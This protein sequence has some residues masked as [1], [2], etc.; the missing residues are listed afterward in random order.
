M[1]LL[2][3]L[4]V[5]VTNKEDLKHIG[6]TEKLGLWFKSGNNHGIFENNETFGSGCCPQNKVAEEGDIGFTE[7]IRLWFDNWTNN[8]VVEEEEACH[9]CYEDYEEQN[10]SLLN[11]V[12]PNIA[13]DEELSSPCCGFGETESIE[14]EEQIGFM[15]KLGSWLGSGDGENN[16]AHDVQK[17]HKEEDEEGCHSSYMI[18]PVF[19][20]VLLLLGLLAFSIYK[21]LEMYMPKQTT[22]P[23]VYEIEKRIVCEHFNKENNRSWFH[24]I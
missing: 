13:F 22:S 18:I 6:F 4:S 16:G 7:K 2:C 12:Q 1:V 17:N 19:L 5:S 20:I 21:C 14:E 23:K 10:I 24:I 9:G 3:L 8:I 15:E 11:L